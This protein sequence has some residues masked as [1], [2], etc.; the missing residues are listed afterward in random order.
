MYEIIKFVTNFI[1]IAAPWDE[2]VDLSC[3]AMYCIKRP[4]DTN[5]G[6]YL[7]CVLLE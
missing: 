2:K 1:T 5:C 6:P 4:R 3:I 7:K